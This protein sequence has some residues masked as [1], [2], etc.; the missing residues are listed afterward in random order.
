VR[1]VVAANRLARVGLENEADVE[2]HVCRLAPARRDRVDVDVV[3]RLVHEAKRAQAGLFAGFTQGS[4][5]NVRIAV[6]VAARLQ[7]ARELAVV[8]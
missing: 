1:F 6:D 7:P 8:Q 5:A 3:D 4:R 2:V